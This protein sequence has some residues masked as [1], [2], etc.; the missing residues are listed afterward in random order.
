MNLYKACLLIFMGTSAFADLT[1]W[2]NAAATK[3]E[4]ALPIGCGRLGGMVYGG[5][6]KDRISLN[7]ST[8]WNGNPGNNNK[9]GAANN[10]A[11]ARQKIF[12]GDATGT[13]SAVNSMIG[14]GQ[15]SFQPV[16]SLYL[17]FSGHTASN[18]YRELD[19]KTA[20]S[21]TTYTYNGV[22]YTREYFASY[23]D[24][25]IIVRLTANQTGKISCAVSLDCPHGNKNF[26][27]SGTDLLLLN[28]TINAIKFQTRV[29]VKA[30]GGTVSTANN[31]I[32]I[33][34]ANSATIIVVV[35]TNFTSY[36]DVSGNQVTRAE[37]YL[38]DIAPKS[39]EQIKT[40]HVNS[41]KEL[42]DR[43]DINLG[44]PTND[45]TVPTGEQVKRFST[46]NDPGLVRLHYQFGRY[47]MISCSRGESQPANLQGIWNESTSPMWGSKYTININTE[48]NYWM[49]H[50]ANLHECLMPLVR[51]LKGMV[52]PER[53][54]PRYTGV[55]IRDGLHITIQI[56]GTGLRL[57]MV[58]GDLP[59]QVERG[60]QQLYGSTTFLHWIKIFWQMSIR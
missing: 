36:N 35:G 55:L 24:Q 34:G 46:S 14:S 53:K 1:L 7:E 15:A 2:Y 27:T 8:V 12:A 50:S 19:L 23:P 3:F 5:V 13:C 21:K 38:N 56:Y 51:K 28:A 47:L 40:A 49:V 16:G 44:T 4:E 43:V 17:E 22:T 20:I 9:A 10:L 25:A 11:N 26:S 6:T 48:M 54:Q 42:F 33:S 18:Y 37:K 32:N 60:C 59:L 29:K 45:S 30:D 57:S 52:A 41:Y 58:Y 39:Y 31:K